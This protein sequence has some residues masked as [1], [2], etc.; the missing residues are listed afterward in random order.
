MARNQIRPPDT[1]VD[2]T[3]VPVL[4]VFQLLFIASPLV[5]TNLVAPLSRRTPIHAD[6]SRKIANPV[7]SPSRIVE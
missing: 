7:R 4:E 3:S 6:E 2:A 1:A 5:I